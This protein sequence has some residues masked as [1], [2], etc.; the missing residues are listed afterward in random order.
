VEAQDYH[1][2]DACIAVALPEA[3]GLAM[4]EAEIGDYHSGTFV[5]HKDYVQAIY[6]CP[7]CESPYARPPIDKGDYL[8]YDCRYGMGTEQ[9]VLELDYGLECHSQDED[10][11]GGT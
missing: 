10:V 7:A 8:C 1:D 5:F 11:A 6:D 2:E 4:R 3:I 9:L